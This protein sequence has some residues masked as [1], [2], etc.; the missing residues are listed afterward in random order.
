MIRAIVIG[1]ALVC[2]A[3]VGAC[4]APL[5]IAVPKAVMAPLTAWIAEH[6][7]YAAPEG[8]PAIFLCQSGEVITYEGR[9]L[10]VDADLRA[11][12]DFVEDRIFLVAPWS[13]D[14]P[15]LL[16]SLLHELI[17]RA[18]FR[19]KDW[20]C[21]AAAEPEAYRLQE[22][23]LAERGIDPGFAWAEIYLRA[24]CSSDHRR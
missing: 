7:D 12:Y 15:M 5:P 23:W 11:A 2:P 4:P 9:D 16:S 19:A 21:P 1:L 18:Q 8:A 10:L 3:A 22:A 6:S 14:D 24:R 13:E 20:P 17:H